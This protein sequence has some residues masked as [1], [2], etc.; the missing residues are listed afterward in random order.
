MHDP[1][2][3]VQPED[4]Y[5]RLVFVWGGFGDGRG[6]SDRRGAISVEET[7]FDDDGIWIYF[8]S[9]LFVASVG[10]EGVWSICG[11]RTP[12]H[13]EINV[14]GVLICFVYQFVF[15]FPVKPW[16]SSIHVFID[17]N[18]AIMINVV[19]GVL[20][21]WLECDELVFSAQREFYDIEPECFGEEI[22]LGCDDG[23]LSLLSNINRCEQLASVLFMR[24]LYPWEVKSDESLITIEQF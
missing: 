17:K 9:I 11:F 16:I 19:L 22:F 13:D 21:L 2:R 7:L 4:R 1:E 15:L 23:S 5:R 6:C 10:V 24:W 12:H 8:R 20:W 3:L 18:N 14:G